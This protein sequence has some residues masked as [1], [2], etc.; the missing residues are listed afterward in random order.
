MAFIPVPAAGFAARLFATPSWRVSG[1]LI[2]V[3][4]VYGGKWANSG[5]PGFAR[6]D[7]T[8][9]LLKRHS[10]LKRDWRRQASSDIQMARKKAGR[11][12]LFLSDQPFFS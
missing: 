11:P 6:R 1:D 7:D 9:V 4:R 2:E 10:R 5:R 3:L 12:G 8:R